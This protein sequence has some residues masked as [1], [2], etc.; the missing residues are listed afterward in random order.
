M[1][2][3][4]YPIQA[5]MTTR[6][7][8]ENS[9][10]IQFEFS[11]TAELPPFVEWLDDYWARSDVQIDDE[12]DPLDDV[13]SVLERKKLPGKSAKAARSKERRPAHADHKRAGGSHLALTSKVKA[14]KV[15][16]AY[17]QP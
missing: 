6:A 15:S 11:S 2:R 7:F 17:V 14:P 13:L 4:R 3:L 10:T 8:F 9:T 1:A 16:S 12:R 5:T